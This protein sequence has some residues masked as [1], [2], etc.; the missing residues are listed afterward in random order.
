MKSAD[1]QRLHARRELIIR[2]G[3]LTLRQGEWVRPLGS[4]A[5]AS[6]TSQPCDVITLKLAAV[7]SFV[8]G[9]VEASASFAIGL[10]DGKTVAGGAVISALATHDLSAPAIDTVVLYVLGLKTFTVCVAKEE[11]AT[12]WDN[13]PVVKRVQLPIRELMP[14][15][16]SASDEFAEAKSRLISGES[17][18]EAEFASIADELRL[19]VNAD[20]PPR[21]IDLALLMREEQGG[22]PQELCALDPIRTLLI[23]PRWRRVIGLAWFDD[24]PQLDPGQT[25]E[26]R[27]TGGFPTTDVYHRVAG[28]HTVPSQTAIPAEVYLGAI[29]LRFPQPRVVELAND[30]R[31]V[32]TVTRRGVRLASRDEPWWHVPSLDDWSVVIDFPDPVN[33]LD[34]DVEPGHQLRFAHGAP[35]I[36]PSAP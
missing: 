32:R 29:R 25:Y 7:Q 4:A 14:E 9:I 21:P 24:D 13:A 18:D 28:F 16:Q 23:H 20:G 10:R 17:L 3:A 34:L 26:Y 22:D 19:L 27:V 15:L 30:D 2:H 11:D 36:T 31:E 33:S 1:F 5:F 12:S 35:W 6:S 8:R